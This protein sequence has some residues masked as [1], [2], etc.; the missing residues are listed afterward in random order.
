M[1]TFIS[2]GPLVWARPPGGIPAGVGSHWAFKKAPPPRGVYSSRGGFVQT[3]PET[4][5]FGQNLANLG[6]LWAY[7]KE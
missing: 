5:R 4:R 1:H 6:K 2:G 3:P 7:F